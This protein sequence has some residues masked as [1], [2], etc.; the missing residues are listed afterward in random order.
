MLLTAF[1]FLALPFSSVAQRQRVPRKTKQPPASS[2]RQESPCGITIPTYDE[3][4]EEIEVK[5]RLATESGTKKYYYNTRG[6][7]DS[8]TGVFRT[9][10]KVVSKDRIERIYTS[11]QLQEFKC[12]KRQ[13]RLLSV[14]DYA[15]NDDVLNSET[16]REPEW[17]DVIPESVGEGTLLAV[18]HLK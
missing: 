13:Q 5:W 11:M 10:V 12:R 8:E 7:C 1:M 17:V 4:L 2:T 6:T 3:F 18:C 15:L 9:W 14:T 16:F